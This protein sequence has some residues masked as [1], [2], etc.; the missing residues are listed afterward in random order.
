MMH[1]QP[2]VDGMK[3]RPCTGNA[4]VKF[5]MPVAIQ[6]YARNAIPS[7]NAQRGEGVGELAGSFEIIGIGVPE[8]L[9]G[10][11]RNYFFLGKIFCCP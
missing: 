4:E 3:R 8:N 6:G 7:L 11:D 5:Q 9:M 2:K 1:G 10:V